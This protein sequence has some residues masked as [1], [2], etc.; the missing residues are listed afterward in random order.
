[1]LIAVRQQQISGSSS[2]AGDAAQG[3]IAVLPTWPSQSARVLSRLLV[4]ICL[5]LSAVAARGAVRRG[6]ELSFKSWWAVWALGTACNRLGNPFPCWLRHSRGL[7]SVMQNQSGRQGATVC[8]EFLEEDGLFVGCSSYELR[9]GADAHAAGPGA[10][11]RQAGSWL[12]QAGAV[13]TIRL[14]A[15]I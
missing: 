7:T 6:K 8:R 10:R 13:A 4:T 1:M 15:T 3:A 12:A 9:N 11:E 5:L 2:G 14:A